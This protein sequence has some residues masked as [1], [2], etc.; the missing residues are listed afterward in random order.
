MNGRDRLPGTSDTQCSG[1]CQL[2]RIKTWIKLQAG[3]TMTLQRLKNVQRNHLDLCK[4]VPAYSRCELSEDGGVL[5]P[6]EHG[7]LEFDNWV[8]SQLETPEDDPVG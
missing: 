1:P 7:V 8:R 3:S 2:W 4:L 5:M 6:N